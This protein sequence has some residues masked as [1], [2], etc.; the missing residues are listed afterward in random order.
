MKI[1]LNVLMCIDV[2]TAAKPVMTHVVGVVTRVLPS[3]DNGKWMLSRHVYE[4]M[5]AEMTNVHSVTVPM[6]SKPVR[7]WT[8]R[9]AKRRW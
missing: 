5:A 7:R 9:R 3:R 6:K 4:T 1:A 8:D 2:R